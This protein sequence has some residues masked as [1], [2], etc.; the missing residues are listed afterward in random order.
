MVVPPA[1]TL[2]S[3]LAR[4]AAAEA[5]QSM[6]T[7]SASPSAS[8]RCV[9]WAAAVSPPSRASHAGTTVH[10]PPAPQAAS[11]VS[12]WPAVSWPSP[13]LSSLSIVSTTMQTRGGSS[14]GGAGAG[15]ARASTSR[16]TTPAPGTRTSRVIVSAIA[17]A[18]PNFSPHTHNFSQRGQSPRSGGCGGR[19]HDVGIDVRR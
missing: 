15:G 7:Q 16:V 13:P 17:A 10:W 18:S 3:R 6:T 19:P 12:T 2:A 5:E 14:A 4:L 1:A 11:A 9:P 8:Q